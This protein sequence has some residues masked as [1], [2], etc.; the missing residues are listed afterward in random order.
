MPL[1]QFEEHLKAKAIFHSESTFAGHP[2]VIGY[3][4]QFRWSWMATQL[5][6]FV[7]AVNFGNTP[8]TPDAFETLF[9]EV[10]AY[11]KTHYTG[12]PKGFQSGL[13]V[14]LLLVGSDVTN[15]AKDYCTQL[16]S[17]KKWAGFSIPIAK[18][19]DSGQAYRF[20]KKPMWGRI[21]Y[22]YFQEMAEQLLT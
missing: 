6:C 7:V 16:K 14:M 22:G 2:A 4:K 15:E 9:P 13:G 10:H 18:N 21:Y 8:I 11:A 3:E 5:N 12:W 19:T 1:S 20:A 17:G